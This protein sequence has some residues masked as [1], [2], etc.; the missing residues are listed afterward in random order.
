[1]R[2]ALVA[3]SLIAA[4]FAALPARAA[5]VRFDPADFAFRP[6][7]GAELPLAAA[8][9][10][11]QGKTVP[12]GHF[13]AGRPV[14]LVLEYLR[15]KTLCGVTL[16]NVVGALAAL[17]LEAG[18]DF[19]LVA[20]SI[21]PRDTPADAA[22]AKAKYAAL[23]DRQGSAGGIDFLTGPEATV[24]RIADAVG[25]AYRYDPALDQYIHPAG[26]VVAAP[27][28]RISRYLL[29]VG[30]T[31]AQIAGAIADAQHDKALGPI[32]RLL[33][34]CHIDGLPPGRFTVPVLAAFT[35]ADLAAMAT[36]IAVFAAIRR[37]RHG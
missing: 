21:D 10:D 4:V 24:R 9:I 11:G 14:I 35:A 7:P 30:V 3:V 36:L 32:G 5:G 16:Q 2:R 26:F 13:F 20:V 12:L 6:H 18:R 28:G 33:L 22:A 31:S 23:Y 1:M 17:P 8:L 25:F 15:C 19:L 27:D 29:G 34:L 37:R